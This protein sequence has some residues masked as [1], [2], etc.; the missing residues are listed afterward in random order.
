MNFQKLNLRHT[1]AIFYLPMCDYFHLQDTV[2][3]PQQENFLKYQMYVHV[4]L[5]MHNLSEK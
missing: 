3:A 4:L 2:S 5:T 1:T